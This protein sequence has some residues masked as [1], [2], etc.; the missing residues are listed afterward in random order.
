MDKQFVVIGCGRFG[1]A[2]STKLIELG[3]EVMVVDISEDIIQNISQTVTYAVQADA[4]DENS[5][6]SLGIRNFD[7]AIISIGTNIQASLLVTLMV[8]ELGVKKVVAK[9]QNELHAKILYKIGADKVVFPEREMGIKVA[10]SLVSKNVLD[11]IELAPDYSIMEVLALD[12]WI[13]KTL[14]EIDMRSKFGI[15][16][17]AIKHE[18]D[19]NISILGSYLIKKNDI[20][21]VIGNNKD[22]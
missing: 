13:G 15:N 14:I 4:T 11:F 16:V 6:N 10:K 1:E 21:V 22:L 3:K 18:Y 17:M 19:I 20:L 8:K 7:V 2:V 12:E 5:I 9:A